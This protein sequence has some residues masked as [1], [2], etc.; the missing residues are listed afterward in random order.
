MIIIKRG[1]LIHMRH[2]LLMLIAST[3]IV[4]RRSI[5]WESLSPREKNNRLTAFARLERDPRLQVAAGI[6]SAAVRRGF[7]SR[8]RAARA[9]TARLGQRVSRAQ[10]QGR[11]DRTTQ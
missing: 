8:Q 11:L 6:G 7:P 2:Y 1:R 9:C 4:S 5:H 10:D 3:A